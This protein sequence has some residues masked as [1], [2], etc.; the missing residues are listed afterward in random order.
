MMVYFDKAVLFYNKNAGD[1]DMEQKL[2]QTVPVLSQSIKELILIH[3][4]SEEDLQNRCREAA[5]VADLI[6]I[7][8]GDGTVHTAINSIAPLEKRPVLAILPGGT[9]NDFSRTLNTS[10]K[11]DEAARSLVQ[12]KI[13]PVDIGK[14]NE[15]FFLNFWGIGLV[16][17]TSKNVDETQKA[18]LGVLSYFM[19]TLRTI[20]EAESFTYEIQADGE[21]REGEAVLIF[22]LNGRFVGTR[23]LPI[24]SLDPQDGKADVLIARNSNLASLRELMSLQNPEADVSQFTELDHFRT[25]ELD[26]RTGTPKEIDMDGEMYAKTPSHIQVLPGHLQFLVPGND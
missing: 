5:S 1:A 12:G 2:A 7:L 23:R 21:K 17:D 15:N 20:R 8:G 22:V 26:I 19:S 6:I 11:L 18:N 3:T 24:D 14:T 13:V 10:Q 25:S 16:S 9:S 4:E